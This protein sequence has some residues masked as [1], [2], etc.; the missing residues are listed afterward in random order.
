MWRKCSTCKSPILTGEIHFVCSVSTCTRRGTDFVFCSV[1]CWDAHVPMMRHKEAYALEKTSP[2]EL[3][4]APSQPTHSEGVRR[5]TVST[6]KTEASSKEELSAEVL[7]IASKVKAY[8]KDRSGLNV[9]AGVMDA[10]SAHVRALCDASIRQARHAERK[11]VM[12]RD[13]PKTRDRNLS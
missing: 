5:R 11:T 9:S 12:E 6:P 10:L 3:E 8:I 4:P 7:V 2:R 13:V 1:N